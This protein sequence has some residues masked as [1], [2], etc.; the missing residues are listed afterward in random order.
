MQ[1]EILNPLRTSKLNF[2]VTETPFIAQITKR[3]RFLKSTTGPQTLYN[4]YS[5]TENAHI[6]KLE[7]E[8]LDLK[9][10][11]TNLQEVLTK[12]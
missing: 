1:I 6:Q 7:E 9:L 4:I 10:I 8:N 3:K 12:S 11:V 2:L 5:S